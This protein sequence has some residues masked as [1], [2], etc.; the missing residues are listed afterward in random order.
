MSQPGQRPAGPLRLDVRDV[1]E[2]SRYEA[3]T[4][5]DDPALAGLVDYELASGRLRLVHTEVLEAFGGQGVG[6]QLVGAVAADARERGLLLVPRCPF[7]MRWL[8]RHP[9]Q[10]DILAQ[11]LDGPGEAASTKSA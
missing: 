11:P 4:V 5:G 8:E 3:T 6:S 1:P 9:E 7:V 10:Q 2:R